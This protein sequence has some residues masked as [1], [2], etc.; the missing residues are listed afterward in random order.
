MSGHFSQPNHRLL[1]ESEKFMDWQCELGRASY[2][3]RKHFD[4]AEGNEASSIKLTYC[5]RNCSNGDAA[6]PHTHEFSEDTKTNGTE[7]IESVDAEF[8]P[9]NQANKENNSL[10]PRPKSFAKKFKEN[11]PE[12]KRGATGHGNGTLSTTDLG[13]RVRRRKQQ[14]LEENHGSNL[15]HEQEVASD[16]NQQE[17]INQ[18]VSRQR[19]RQAPKAASEKGRVNQCPRTP[20]RKSESEIFPPPNLPHG[21]GMKRSRRVAQRLAQEEPPPPPLKLPR[22]HVVLTRKEIQEDWMKITGHKYTGKPR[23]STLVQKGLGLC[24][25]LMCPSSIEYLNDPH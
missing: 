13:V 18:P 4:D 22:L 24:T 23:K 14:N 16:H 17:K 9:S 10:Q 19:R 8:F 5:K 1:M 11:K 7:P 21:K 3:V 20:K 25:A 12:Q 6:K 15:R 2:G